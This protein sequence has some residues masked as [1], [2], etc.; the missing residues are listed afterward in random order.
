[1]RCWIRDDAGSSAVDRRIWELATIPFDLGGFP[2]SYLGRCC[3]VA[4][5]RQV[6]LFYR[7]SSPGLSLREDS[8]LWI[9]GRLKGYYVY[10]WACVTRNPFL[11]SVSIVIF[12]RSSHICSMVFPDGFWGGGRYHSCWISVLF[13]SRAR[14]GSLGNEAVL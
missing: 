1:V 8:K 2:T 10:V 13:L 5:P 9:G 12:L 6:V 7:S 11:V 3:V 4:V 14:V